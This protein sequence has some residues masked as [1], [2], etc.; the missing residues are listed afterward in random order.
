MKKSIK[1][2]LFSAL[3][4]PGMGHFYLKKH[5]IGS[6]ILG[7]TFIPLYVV[8]TKAIAQAQAIVDRIVS[9]DAQ[10]DI[11]SISDMLSKQSGGADAESMSFAVMA[12]I[13]IWL[14][15]I[16]DAYRRGSAVDKNSEL[17]S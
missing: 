11:A 14:I 17:Q 15:A 12:F 2:A 6:F 13:I 1:A 9:G 3:V 5:I 4:F 7:I 16:I 8:V 10:G